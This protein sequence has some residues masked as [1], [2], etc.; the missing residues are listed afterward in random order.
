MSTIRGWGGTG[1]AGSNRPSARCSEVCSICSSAASR[2][3]RPAT[4]GNAATWGAVDAAGE[5][6]P[7]RAADDV[8]PSKGE[9]CCG[10]SSEEPPG[11][12]AS[13][14]SVST[15]AGNDPG[16]VRRAALPRLGPTRSIRHR[17][18]KTSTHARASAA[19][20][21]PSSSVAAPRVSSVTSRA[22]TPT[23]GEQH[24]FRRRE[25][26]AEAGP[27]VQTG[28]GRRRHDRAVAQA[29]SSGTSRRL[30]EEQLDRAHRVDLVAAPLMIFLVSLR[31]PGWAAARWLQRPEHP[32]HCLL[33]PVG[34]CREGRVRRPPS[35]SRCTPLG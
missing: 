33:A 23:A 25:R 5:R 28:S 2:R 14:S 27:C 9:Q 21:S 3:S 35:W 13:R 8:R 20:N 12:A 19:R 11:S 34:G 29:E 32:G 16:P 4:T 10:G 6:A 17:G 1:D 24:R 30:G 7:R 22:G 15:R 31:K 26:L 18:T